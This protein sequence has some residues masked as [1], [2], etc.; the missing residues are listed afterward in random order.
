MLKTSSSLQESSSSP[1]SS[2]SNVLLVIL[3]QWKHKPMDLKISNFSVTQSLIVA[4][5]SFDAYCR[6]NQIFCDELNE[7]FDHCWKFSSI[8]NTGEDYGF[9][10]WLDECNDLYLAGLGEQIPESVAEK[11]PEAIK[12]EF[13]ELLCCFT[14]IVHSVAWA[15]VT[16]EPIENMKK[17][18]AFSSRHG[19]P[20][21]DIS[22]YMIE[23]KDS[24]ADNF[25]PEI[26]IEELEL[27]RSISQNY[28][29]SL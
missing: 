18:I 15:K 29:S 13:Y 27:W 16:D 5:T 12:D 24:D 6:V 11:I 26:T 28:L 23:K 21:P 9:S 25:C 14:E 2:I 8:S 1:K 10:D 19:I 3:F 22:K 4:A 17:V 7:M 20:E